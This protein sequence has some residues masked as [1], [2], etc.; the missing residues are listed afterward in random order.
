MWSKWL[1]CRKFGHSSYC[2]YVGQLK[3]IEMLENHHRWKFNVVSSNSL[4]WKCILSV[5]R[6][7]NRI[8]YFYYWIN[9][10]WFFLNIEI[11][12]SWLLECF[13]FSIS[14]IHPPA[15]NFIVYWSL[16]LGSQSLSGFPRSFYSK[17]CITRKYDHA[18]R[19]ICVKETFPLIFPLIEINIHLNTQPKRST[20]ENVLSEH[21]TNLRPVMRYFSCARWIDK[22]NS[23]CCSNGNRYQW[24]S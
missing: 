12:S 16:Y 21:S 18:A 3:C 9:S 14:P 4:Y 15:S 1:E 22:M 7:N 19:I 8:S 24:N 17:P 6:V 13:P 2:K 10:I 11:Q 23:C 20:D 5:E